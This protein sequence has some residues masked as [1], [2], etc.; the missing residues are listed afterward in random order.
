MVEGQVDR[1]G[2]NVPASRC[3]THTHTHS[4]SLTHMHT[5]SLL[6][7]S[8]VCKI[9]WSS[10]YMEIPDILL[11]QEQFVGWMQCLLAFITQPVPQVGV[12]SSVPSLDLPLILLLDPS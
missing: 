11:Q 12:E 1:V 9:F 7:F 2:V 4:H 8:Q 5:H 6:S 10:C 3:L